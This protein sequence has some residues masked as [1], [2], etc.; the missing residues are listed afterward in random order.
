M[1]TTTYRFTALASIALASALLLGACGN[2]KAS[3]VQT[4]S[5]SSKTVQSSSSSSK[6]AVKK[7]KAS[8]SSSNAQDNSVASSSSETSPASSASAPAASSQTALTTTPHQ[9]QATASNQAGQEKETQTGKGSWNASN[10]TGVLDFSQDTP[11]HVAP[12]KNSAIAFTQPADTSL[13]WDDYTI[14][15]DENWY[16]VVVKKGDTTEHYYVAYSDVGH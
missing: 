11:V 2:Q 1:K 12:D 16:T 3:T 5:S 15:S 7:T 4:S 6:K 8:S 10:Q 9:G 13:E 14:N